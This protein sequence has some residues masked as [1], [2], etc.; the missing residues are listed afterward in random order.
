MVAHGGHSPRKLFSNA[1]TSSI[2]L[3]SQYNYDD[4]IPE[5]MHLSF[6]AYIIILKFIIENLL[7]YGTIDWVSLTN[8]KYPVWVYLYLHKLCEHE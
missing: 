5:V 6:D 4:P 3:P 8:I 2:F 7:R 1:I